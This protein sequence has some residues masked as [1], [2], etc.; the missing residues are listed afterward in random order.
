MAGASHLVGLV[1]DTHGRVDARLFAALEGVERIIHAGDLEDVD[2]LIELE[3]I[4][5]VTAVRGN[6]DHGTRCS[7]LPAFAWLEVDGV[8]FVATHIRNRALSEDAARADGADVY[9]FGHSHVPFAERRPDGMLV[10]N[11]G[12]AFRPRGGT[13]RS[14]AIVEVRD[15][16]VIGW[17]HVPLS[18]LD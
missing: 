8:R 11:P 9:V 18:S 2:T 3:A 14:V 16:A 10:I 13:E 7:W 5:P 17:R 4:A 12:S 15:G 6:C 1:S